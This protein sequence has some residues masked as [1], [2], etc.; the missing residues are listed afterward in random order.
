VG[1]SGL[2]SLLVKE[3]FLTEQDRQTITHTCGQGS[4]AF[5]K[6]ILAMGLLDED[7]LA[8]F[9]AER[10]RYQIAAKDFLNHLDPDAIQ[11]FDKRLVSKLEVI[12]LKKDLG[13][14]TVAV[15][16]PL[17]RGTLKQ[18]EFFTGL[19]VNP[20]VV[21]LS[22]LYEGLHKIDP[23]FR[24]QHTA[25]T[26][27]LQNHAQSA[28]VRQKLEAEQAKGE[29]TRSAAALEKSSEDQ[30]LFE[31][32]TEVEDLDSSPIEMEEIDS[33]PESFEAAGDDLLNE[34]FVA[35]SE[36]SSADPFA[37]V[38][39]DSDENQGM[40]Q[41]EDEREEDGGVDMDE[42]NLEGMSE[43]DD[44]LIDRLNEQ[45]LEPLSSPAAGEPGPFARLE[46]EALDADFDVRAS[47]PFVSDEDQS[48][49]RNM[50]MLSSVD[51]DLLRTEG[52]GG[53][54]TEG[55]NDELE[56]SVELPDD[57]KQDDGGRA[58]ALDFEMP[59][60]STFGFEETKPRGGA[61]HPV[62][63]D[64][65]KVQSSSRTLGEPFDDDV[66]DALVEDK[67]PSLDLSALTL[68]Q[69]L[70]DDHILADLHAGRDGEAPLSRLDG[71]GFA[72]DEGRIESSLAELPKVDKLSFS[73]EEETSIDL[74][75]ARESGLDAEDDI[76]LHPKKR[77][78]AS[79]KDFGLNPTSA[80]N[81]LIVRLS[82]AFSKNAVQELLESHLPRIGRAGCL[83]NV[84]DQRQILWTEGKMIGE[85]LGPAAIHPMLAGLKERQWK[86]A[87]L[88]TGESWTGSFLKVRIYRDKDW[89]WA[90]SLSEANDS[91]IFREV[92]ESVV[93][94]VNGKLE[95]E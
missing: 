7:E 83:I 79:Q 59:E 70:I 23:S 9:F 88:K 56:T 63:E 62:S 74:H 6:S 71:P 46:E 61:A 44:S 58:D 89:L 92:V 69:D 37:G 43:L 84:L 67:E 25:L 11:S 2:G 5:A 45:P 94:Q 18:L 51:E 19:E 17:D 31:E 57:V 4:W 13:K 8:A 87:E 49:D 39:S 3:G 95:G 35:S 73:D 81:E 12:P 50:N 80:L 36:V 10:T 72:I 34:N 40:D 20:V 48:L 22:Q 33:D 82:L 30:D 85:Q 27:F 68:E 93:S 60:V 29:K 28:W 78:T 75:A 91:A 47:E 1:A 16:D 64:D 77:A 52:F 86:L 42:E 66:L 41:D 24:L 65:Q 90:H 26:H 32:V 38:L 55:P 54:E 76:E 21:P 14:I 53:D 15:L